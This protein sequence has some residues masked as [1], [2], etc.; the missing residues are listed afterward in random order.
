MALDAPLSDAPVLVGLMSGTSLDGI[1]AAAVRFHRTGDGDRPELLAFESLAYTPEQR[2]Q[3]AAGMVQ[4]SAQSY[5]RLNVDLGRW[6]ADA[7]ATVMRAAGPPTARRCGTSPGIPPG[8]LAT[9]P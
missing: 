8:R 9:R 6:L 1:A 4:G 2:A 3:L 5:C 7:A